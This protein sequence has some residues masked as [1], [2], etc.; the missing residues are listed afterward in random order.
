MRFCETETTEAPAEGRSIP[1]R[2]GGGV[3]TDGRDS[4]PARREGM[5]SLANQ[6]TDPLEGCAALEQGS[7]A[8]EAWT[9]TVGLRKLV[10]PRDLARWHWKW[11]KSDCFS[12]GAR[13]GGGMVGSPAR[14]L[15]LLQNKAK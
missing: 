9:G 3:D 1:G 2:L 4:S 6:F 7:R 15:G 12:S 8:H 14:L 5:L 11:K 10:A 13:N